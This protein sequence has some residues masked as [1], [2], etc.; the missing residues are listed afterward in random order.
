MKF[1]DLRRRLRSEGFEIVDQ[2]GAHEQWKCAGR[3]GRVTVSGKDGQDV[4]TG[5]L[6]NI[7]RQ[8]GWEWR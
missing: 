5:T 6:R 4:P 7:F 2:E 8:A 3:S 1:R